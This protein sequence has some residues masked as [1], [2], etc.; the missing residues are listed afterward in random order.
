ME[1]ISNR[2]MESIT[3]G[4]PLVLAGMFITSYTQVLN[5]IENNPEDYTFLMDWYYE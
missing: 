1:Q 5:K 2:D 4:N 3:G